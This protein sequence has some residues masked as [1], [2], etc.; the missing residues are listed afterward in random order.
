MLRTALLIAACLPFAAYATTAPA[1]VAPATEAAPIA[2]TEQTGDGEM[3]T[4]PSQKTELSTDRVVVSVPLQE[5]REIVITGMK[6]CAPDGL[7]TT[8]YY[9]GDHGDSSWGGRN[10]G[11]KIDCSADSCTARFGF[12]L[13]TPPTE[14]KLYR[15]ESGKCKSYRV[16]NASELIT[17]SSYKASIV[18]TDELR[19]HFKY[20]EMT[21][22]QIERTPN[23]L[24]K[25]QQV[26]NLGGASMLE[27]V[28]DATRPAEDEAVVY[29]TP[30]T[31]RYTQ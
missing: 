14:L 22:N 29:G 2:P 21:A 25:T 31:F 9:G 19:A 12:N 10:Y 6:I 7:T 26:I 11:H 15:E 16:T 23:S 20:P 18:L 27:L 17:T 13:T 28:Y 4:P 8:A 30:F 5:V 24:F 1:P 3:T